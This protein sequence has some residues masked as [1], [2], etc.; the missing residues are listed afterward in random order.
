[1][2]MLIAIANPR[3]VHAV[4]AAL[5]HI[6]N[7]PTNAVPAVLAPPASHIYYS[8]HGASFG[9]TSSLLFNLT[10]VPA[11]YTLVVESVTLQTRIESMNQPMQADFYG[12]PIPLFPYPGATYL[13]PFH[14]SVGNLGGRVFIGGGATPYCEA[15]LQSLSRDGDLQCWVSGY[16]VPA[17]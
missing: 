10:Q 14:N 12:I 2:A 7:T 6:T 8:A 4:A 17:Q 9:G 11:G 1:M 13:T 5:V 16:L 15:S 3:A